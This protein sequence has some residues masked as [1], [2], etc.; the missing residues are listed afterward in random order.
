MAG[1]PDNNFHGPTNGPKLTLEEAPLDIRHDG[2]VDLRLD[3]RLAETRLDHFTAVGPTD[4][5][6]PDELTYSRNVFLPLTTACRYTCSYC[7]FFD[8]PGR[9]SLMTDG[10]VATALRNGGAAGCREALFT[11]G[12][13][14]D[15]RYEELQGRLAERGYESILDYLHDACDTA[16]DHGLLPHSNPGDLPFEALRRLKPVNASMGVMLET[17]AS[18]EAHSGP[19]AKSPARRLQTMEYAGR[20]RIPFTTGIL[21]GIGETVRDRAFSLWCIRR[22][23]EAHDHIQEVIVQPVVPNDRSDFERPPIEELRRTVAMARYILP[24]DVEVQVPPNLSPV[25][26]LIDCGVGDLGGVS[27]VTDDYVNPDY[28]W[29]EIE[30]LHDLAEEV[31]VPLREREPV[32]EGYRAEDWVSDRV[33]RLLER[34]PGERGRRAVMK[35]GR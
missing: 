4:V 18:V 29:P 5:T 25:K 15:A 28:P 19:R 24:G 9:A 2:N 32:Y 22:L 7:T 3:Y 12:D 30:R 14:P 33:R 13:R 6:G 17:T 8:P 21:V 27:P 31:G 34:D 35:R 11:L 26:R 23:H 1:V 16:L 10:E 20:V